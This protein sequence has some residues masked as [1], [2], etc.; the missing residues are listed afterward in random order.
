MS[1]AEFARRFHHGQEI[2]RD[3][4][5]EQLRVYYDNGHEV[6]CVRQD[7]HTT[8]STLEILGEDDAASARDWCRRVAMRPS[9]PPSPSRT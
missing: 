7:R 6:G 9:S 3:A 1:W 2:G 4:T 5:D 8:T